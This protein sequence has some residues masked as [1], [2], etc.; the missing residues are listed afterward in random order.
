MTLLALVNA[1]SSGI[2][3]NWF[4]KNQQVQSAELLLQE[5]PITRTHVRPSRLRAA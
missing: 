3:R 4:H 5:R 1:V 2:V